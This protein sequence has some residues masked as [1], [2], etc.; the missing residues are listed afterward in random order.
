MEVQADNQF[1]FTFMEATQHALGMV[2]SW[3][4]GR[5]RVDGD[6]QR[7]GVHTLVPKYCGSLVEP[8]FFTFL[9][10]LHDG[11]RVGSRDHWAGRGGTDA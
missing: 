5:L 10:H 1:E 8:N 9:R 3:P 2:G 7:H 4:G 6:H 11:L